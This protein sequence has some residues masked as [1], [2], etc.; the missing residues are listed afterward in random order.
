MTHKRRLWKVTYSD[1]LLIARWYLPER[2]I[3]IRTSHVSF[4][5]FDAWQSQLNVVRYWTC[6]LVTCVQHYAFSRTIL[7]KLPLVIWVGRRCI[8]LECGA[9]MRHESASSIGRLDVIIRL[10]LDHGA[11]ANTQDRFL[12]DPFCEGCQCYSYYIP[13]RDS[14]HHLRPVSIKCHS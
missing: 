4:C 9:R 13:K 7:N 3:Q 14:E 2:R 1:P 11:N 12:Y 8:L 6:H 10:L 5:L